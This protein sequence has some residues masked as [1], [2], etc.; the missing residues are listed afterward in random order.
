MKTSTYLKHFVL[1]IW[2]LSLQTVFSQIGKAN[3]V[4]LPETYDFDYIYKLKMTHKKGDIT[5]DYYLNEDASYFGF[6][7]E[8]LSKSNDN[9]TIFSVM[10]SDL[11]IVAMFMEMMG[12]KVVQ[13]TKLKV[14]N[15]DSEED[16]SDY[17]FTEIDPKTI[18]GY[19]CEGFVSENDK[20]KITFYITDDAPV[21]FSK[22]FESNT[23][24]M[25]KGFNAALLKKYMDN[26]L[27]MEMIYEDKKKSKNN[28][29]MQ[30]VSLEETE[31]SIDTTEYGS[32]LS[33]FGG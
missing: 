8:E 17:T 33:A 24:Q 1:L 4:V 19:E 26:G 20:I 7:T 32:M 18:N 25:P 13:K 29:T 12:K 3:K 30:C 10:D 21:S 2:F 11:E 31:F 15:L 5:F 28:M 16:M 14:S 22:A 9:G 23:K 27:M 6:N